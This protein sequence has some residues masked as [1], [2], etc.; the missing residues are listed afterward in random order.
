M[1]NHFSEEF[2]IGLDKMVEA[3]CLAVGSYFVETLFIKF[4]S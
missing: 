2:L 1:L 4:F 3:L